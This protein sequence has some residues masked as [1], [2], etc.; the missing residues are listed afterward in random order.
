MNA[1]YRY[2]LKKYAAQAIKES[3]ASVP[4]YD[5]SKNIRKLGGK[6]AIQTGFDDVTEGAVRKK[7]KG[8]EIRVHPSLKRNQKEFNFAVARELG[9]LYA[10]MGFHTKDSLWE[11]QEDGVFKTFTAE[12][13]I[14]ANYFAGAFLMPRDNFV[15]T[16][17]RLSRGGQLS[18]AELAEHFNVTE[19]AVRNR[20]RLLGY[21]GF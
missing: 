9:H 19:A 2:Y 7:G 18:V 4:V 14:A 1:A 8:F 15:V 10:H 12:D 16:M 21:S 5:I 11:K 3:D 20:A 6:I 17:N 13:D